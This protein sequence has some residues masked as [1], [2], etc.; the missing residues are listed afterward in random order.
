VRMRAHDARPP[1]RAFV[2]SCGGLVGMQLVE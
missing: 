1:P 2:I